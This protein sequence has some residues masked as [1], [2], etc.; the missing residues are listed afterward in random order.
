MADNF[1]ITIYYYNPNIDTRLEFIRRSEELE[2]L[3]ELNID[4]NT[5]VEDYEP[6]EYDEVVKGLENLGEGSQRCHACYKLRLA[7]TAEYAQAHDY[8]Y[9][10]TTLSVSPHKNTQWLHEIGQKLEQVFGVKY[11]DEDF[12]KKDGY[13]RSLELSRELKLYRQD[14]CGCKYSK[15]EARQRQISKDH[16]GYSVH[17]P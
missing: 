8:D 9:F 14:Y 10:A 13:K 15:A 3:R 16:A 5:V 7:K 11:L 6:D 4:F 1:A 2:K 17:R 12:K